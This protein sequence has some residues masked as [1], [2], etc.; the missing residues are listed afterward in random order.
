MLSETAVSLPQAFARP[1]APTVVMV[2]AEGGAWN[3]DWVGV[4]MAASMVPCAPVHL[5]GTENVTVSR[6]LIT[7]SRYR[8]KS[9]T[10]FAKRPESH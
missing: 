5:T 10:W 1:D 6:S 7:F 2:A 4:Q 9:T 8:K 3:E